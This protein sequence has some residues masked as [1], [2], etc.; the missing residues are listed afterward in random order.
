MINGIGTSD[1]RGLNKGRGSKFCIGSR[2][3]QTPE[4]GQRTYQPKR[5]EYTNKDED[6]SSKIQ[7]DKNIYTHICVY[8]YIHT[9]TYIYVY[10]HIYIYIQILGKSHLIGKVVLP[11]II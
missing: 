9:H 10:T 8:L 6:N 2:V 11:V 4:E 7:N 5:C 3:R 1:P